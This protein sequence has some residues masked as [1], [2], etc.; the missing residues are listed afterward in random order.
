MIRH[1]NGYVTRYFHLSRFARGLALN[2]Q[3]A[4]GDLIGYVGQ[5]GY[6]T[7]P[8]LCFRMTKAGRPVNPLTHHTPQPGR[9]RINR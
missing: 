8:H 6:V 4:Q 5:T 2:S 1:P 7:G 3:V 9:S